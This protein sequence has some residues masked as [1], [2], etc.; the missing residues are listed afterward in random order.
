[1][2]S[3]EAFLDKLTGRDFQAEHDRIASDEGA[4][5]LGQEALA[6][7]EAAPFGLVPAHNE[8]PQDALEKAVAEIEAGKDETVTTNARPDLQELGGTADVHLVWGTRKRESFISA[9]NAA[10][11]SS[12]ECLKQ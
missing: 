4:A 10:G 3:H 9:N 5:I 1:M 7:T 6:T 8:S 2:E 12:L 11:G